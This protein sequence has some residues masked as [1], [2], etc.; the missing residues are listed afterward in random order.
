M[1]TI[2][3]NRLPP[4]GGRLLDVGCGEGRHCIGA[5]WFLE[6]YQIL[7]VDLS[8]RDLR[9]AQQ[10]LADFAQTCP[11]NNQVAWIQNSA[12]QLPFADNSFDAVICSEVLEHIHEHQP[13]LAELFR[14]VKPGG[15]LAVSVPRFWPEKICW[16]LSPD[17]AKTPGGH[18]Q[19]F[20]PWQLRR[21][22]AAAGFTLGHEH[23]AHSLHSIYWWLRCAF[24]SRGEK[25]LPCRLYHRLLV[26]DLLHKPWI[27]QCLDRLCNPIFGKSWVIYCQKPQALREPNTA[28]SAEAMDLLHTP[29]KSLDAH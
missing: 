29:G 27:T 4:Q 17:Y 28:N 15:Q 21:D 1:H 24:W 13:V 5:Y 23:H 2:D 14:V 3:F 25:F 12:Q 26:W 8:A 11:K 20:R 19:I 10:R 6:N 7:G 16:W 18:V 22:L 9:S